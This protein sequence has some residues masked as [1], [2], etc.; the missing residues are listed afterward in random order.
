MGVER[1]LTCT[2]TDGRMLERDAQIS[3]NVKPT[4][5]TVDGG[6]RYTYELALVDATYTLG[7]SIA[8]SPMSF[9]TFTMSG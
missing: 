1:S 2:D 5:F 4:H 7:L 6:S 9:L 3:D 8:Q